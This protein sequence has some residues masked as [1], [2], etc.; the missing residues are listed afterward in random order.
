MTKK[1]LG[2]D[3]GVSSVGLSV[4]IHENPNFHGKFYSGNTASKNLDRTTNRG[5]RRGYQRFQKRRDDLYKILKE[6]KMFPNDELFKLNSLELY[7][8]RANA[9][10][11]KISLEELGRV[12]ILL[13]QRRGFLSNRKSNSED[14][15]S[16]DYKKRISELEG[17]LNGKTIG[18]QL[19][20]ELENAKNI[21]E[22]L[23]RERT[24][25]RRSYIE[26]YDR[27]WEFQ[28]QFYPAILTG[29]INEDDNKG[30]LYN[31]VRNRIIFYQRP[32]KSQK[33]LVSECPFEKHHKAVAKSSP[34]FEIFK[35]WQRINDLEVAFHDGSKTKP[36]SAQKKL[37]FDSLFYGDNLN[38]KFKLTVTEIKKTLGLK[39]NEGYLNFTELDGSR[40]YSILKSTLIKAEIKINVKNGNKY[41]SCILV[42]KR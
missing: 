29:G 26:E 27:I 39:R 9:V 3:I 38:N 28:K 30:T 5:I 1:I 42:G 17:E 15:N 12:L 33:G 25:L 32:L 7:R 24:Y 11:K 13:N 40:T 23:I 35:I 20:T 36:N 16:T 22:I 37:L 2:L 31:T 41:L 19:Y 8:I 10:T 18:Q 6:N 21:F 34:Y 14:E 4:I